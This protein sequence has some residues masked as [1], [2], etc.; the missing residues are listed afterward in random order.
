M[1]VRNIQMFLAYGVC[2][3]YIPTVRD[4]SLPCIYLHVLT[5]RICQSVNPLPS[6]SDN[7]WF[8]A[9]VRASYQCRR[10][11]AEGGGLVCDTSS[12][13]IVLDVFLADV[14]AGLGVSV[15]V[16]TYFYVGI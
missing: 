6:G 10:L 9:C 2:C 1:D 16:R 14:C 7:V 8:Y 12:N 11:V 5:Q 3:I 13:I 4:T 15:N